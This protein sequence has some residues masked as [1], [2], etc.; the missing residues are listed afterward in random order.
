MKPEKIDGV[1]DGGG[2]VAV[3]GKVIVRKL[4]LSVNFASTVCVT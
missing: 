4:A 1:A 2:I 3:A